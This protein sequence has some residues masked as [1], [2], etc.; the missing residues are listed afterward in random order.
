MIKLTEEQ[1][2][3]TVM[4][5]AVKVPELK[6]LHHI[7]NGGKRSKTEAVRFKLAG[8]K[9]GVADLF[10]PLPIPGYSAGLY[11]E[12]KSTEGKPSKEQNEFLNDMNEAGYDTL[13]SHGPDP[14]IREL[15][16]YV[17]RYRRVMKE[18]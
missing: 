18:R 6:W 4:R 14:A 17:D 11:I 16:L 2:Q 1:S 10:L 9:A 3:I 7:P 13:V 8:V 15:G 12:I 5:Y